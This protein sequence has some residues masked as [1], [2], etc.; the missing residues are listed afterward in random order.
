M[1]PLRIHPGTAEPLPPLTPGEE[2]LP[3]GPFSPAAVYPSTDQRSLPG[4]LATRGSWLGS[5]AFTGR[6]VTGWLKARSAVRIMIAG[7]LAASPN[8]LELEARLRNGDSLT[9]PFHGE[10]PKEAWVPWLISLPDDAVAVR[11]KA[12]DGSSVG[13]AI[14]LGVGALLAGFA[15]AKANLSYGPIGELY[16]GKVSRTLEVGGHSDSRISYH[17]VQM[18]ANHLAPFAPVANAYFAPW[19]FTSRGPLAGILAGVRLSLRLLSSE[20]QRACSSSTGEQPARASCVNVA[21]R[22][23]FRASPSQSGHWLKRDPNGG[24]GP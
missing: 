23:S 19:S 14:V 4:G 18:V 8:H 13:G 20:V 9:I 3:N 1:D 22:F 10:N 21:T 12:V 15:V 16:G 7:Y 17:V 6:Y 24:S 5:D 2:L 11:V